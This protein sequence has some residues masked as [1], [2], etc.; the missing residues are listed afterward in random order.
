LVSGA[1][2]WF[3]LFK[4]ISLF[5]IFKIFWGNSLGDFKAIFF[6]NP[7]DM[8]LF[9][10]LMGV[11]YRTWFGGFR[12]NKG[13]CNSKLRV[14]CISKLRV[15]CI[16]SEILNWRNVRIRDWSLQLSYRILDWV[17]S[18]TPFYF[19]IFLVFLMNHHFGFLIL[20]KIT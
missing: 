9:Y 10:S 15:L 6:K 18:R 12:F 13:S 14:L 2:S 17:F 16:H 11:R 20:N 3:H 4:F 5:T 7:F 19:W 8:I 1:I